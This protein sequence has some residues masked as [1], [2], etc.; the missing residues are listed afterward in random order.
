MILLIPASIQ[1]KIVIGA[2]VKKEEETLRLNGG[3]TKLRLV[4]VI[5]LPGYCKQ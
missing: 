1:D 3:W 4:F 2:I 5:I